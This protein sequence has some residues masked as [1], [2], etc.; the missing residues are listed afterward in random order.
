MFACCS[1]AIIFILARGHRPSGKP[2]PYVFADLS[3]NFFARVYM[4][5]GPTCLILRIYRCFC[6]SVVPHGILDMVVTILDVLNFAWI[7]FFIGFFGQKN[8]PY[9]LLDVM[10][11]YK[12]MGKGLH[13][14]SGSARPPRSISPDLAFRHR[15][16]RTLLPSYPVGCAQTAVTHLKLCCGF[17]GDV[18]LFVE[19]VV[20]WQESSWDSAHSL[21]PVVLPLSSQFDQLCSH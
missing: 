14:I 3:Y 1:T 6:A 2:P 20:A 12:V 5:F 10:L 13:A 15:F 19:A 9:F 4:F 18:T 21:G 8:V 16:Q 7:S 11:S 17:L